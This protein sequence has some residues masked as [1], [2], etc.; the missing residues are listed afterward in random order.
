MCRLM[1]FQFNKMRS[2]GCHFFSYLYNIVTIIE[3]YRFDRIILPRNIFFCHKKTIFQLIPYS[4]TNF[5]SR[6]KID[7]FYHSSVIYIQTWNDSF[8][9]HND[10]LPIIPQSSLIS[11]FRYHCFF[12]D[13]TGMRIHS[14]VLPKHGYVYCILS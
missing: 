5:N 9:M 10:V 8:C 1:V 2:S 12:P 3:R 11:E 6:Y 4:Y 14:P 7:S 13:G